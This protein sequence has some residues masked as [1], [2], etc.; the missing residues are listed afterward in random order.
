MRNPI[1]KLIVAAVILVACIAGIIVWTHTGSGIA[2]A[3]VLA[4]VQQI[5]SYTY[6]MTMRI[7][8][9]GPTGMD[10][11]QSTEGSILVARDS[12]MKMTMDMPVPNGA[13]V[14]RIETYML[15]QEKAMITLMPANKQYM[16]MELDD[17]LVEKTRQQNY[18]PSSMLKQ[19]LECKY[20]SLGRS[21]IDGVEV[22]GFHTSDP[23]YNA[24]TEGQVDV[25]IW[26]DVK[27][28][29]P[30]RE[31]TDMLMGEM[32]IHVIVHSF[33]WNCLVDAD[34]FKP[35]IPA[36]YTALPGSGMKLPAMNE[37]STIAGL[38]LCADLTGRYPEKLDFETVTSF[39]VKLEKKDT[40]IPELP[41]AP[42]PEL[43]EPPAP[44]VEENA[45]RFKPEDLK[46]LMELPK[47]ERAQKMKEYLK[48]LEEHR[49]KS[50]QEWS[51]WDEQNKKWEE[52]TKKWDEEL[53]KWQEQ[54]DLRF[55]QMRKRVDQMGE[56]AGQLDETMNKFMPIIST[57]TFYMTLVGE[58]KEPA[59]Y[60]NVVTPQDADKV[61]MRWK[62]S[63]NE[64]RVIYGDLHAETVTP[65]KLAELEKALPK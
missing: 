54:A 14:E 49:K 38:K 35:V 37:E 57:V 2:L 53:K 22:E 58:K 23:N 7:S 56:R 55:E 65:E 62:V 63:D 3:D 20:E 44:P 21:V 32:H 33:Q 11:N 18:D 52:Q 45:E 17:T 42:R 25:T 47:E 50:E 41:P 34:T 10:M 43:P 60:G 15:P 48:K 8:G 51:K 27:T 36:D 19:I 59:Y 1:T 13:K 5:T 24:G 4:Q 9:K 64:Y 28:Q 26:V 12:G 29:L 61:L 31:E 16:R 30:V 39:I 46:K 40:S 6:Q